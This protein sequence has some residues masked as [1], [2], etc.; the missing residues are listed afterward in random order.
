MWCDL[1]HKLLWCVPFLPAPSPSTSPSTSD[2]L[3]NFCVF[4]TALLGPFCAETACGA[5][6]ALRA[7]VPAPKAQDAQIQAPRARVAFSTFCVFETVLRDPFC[8]EPNCG[9]STALR[10]FVPAPKVRYAHIQHA[11]AALVFS[12]FS[13]YCVFFTALAGLFCGEP[14]CGASA[15]LRAFIPAPKAQYTQIQLPCLFL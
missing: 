14:A 12:E 8:A 2:V 3:L 7:F 15:A 1:Q 5:R 10:A 9:A 6:A 13:V 4:C 11:C